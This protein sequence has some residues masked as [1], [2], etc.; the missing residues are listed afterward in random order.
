MNIDTLGIGKEGIPWLGD[1]LRLYACW[2]PVSLY[3]CDSLWNKSFECA[4]NQAALE[5]NFPIRMG[6]TPYPRLVNEGNYKL[7]PSDFRRK[8]FWAE[9]KALHRR[10][11]AREWLKL[12]RMPSGLNSPGILRKLQ[13]R[14]FRAATLP[15]LLVFG[16]R[17]ATILFDWEIVALGTLFHRQP[18]CPQV[19]AICSR[20]VRA[21]QRGWR[22]LEWRSWKKRW[23]PK[24][25][26]FAAIKL[27]TP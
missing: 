20:N 24:K 17:T 16:A 13:S 26:L 27:D 22:G 1:D 6:T 23:N 10:S 12:C 7:F 18:R 8:E 11:D 15:E 3:V 2:L 19:L 5:G 21:R 14:G 4:F 9:T 25:T